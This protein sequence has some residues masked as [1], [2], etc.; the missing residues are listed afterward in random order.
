MDDDPREPRDPHQPHAAHEPA[1]G[2]PL[3]A[4]PPPHAGSAAWPSGSGA[5]VPWPLDVPSE[6]PFD[7]DDPVSAAAA[8]PP[9]V[10]VWRAVGDTRPWGT[11]LV[12]LAWG[13]VFALQAARGELGETTAAIARGANLAVRDPLVVLPRL[14][15]STFLHQSPGHVFFNALT[16]L[17]LGQAVEWV[18]ARAAFWCVFALGG[19]AASLASVSWHLVRHGA[20]SYV[21]LGGSGAVFALG[22]A[23]LPGAWRLRSY[24]AVGRARALAAVVLMLTL[25]G[26]AAGFQTHGTDNAAHAAGFTAG[27]VLGALAPLNSRLSGRPTGPVI[28]VAGALGAL[29]LAVALARVLRG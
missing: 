7:D 19:A 6:P 29:A 11:M 18:F 21:S 22:G 12:L 15:A 9:P 23:L 28:R 26:L 5:E 1:P 4:G 20:G 3:P 27:L 10:E 13:V 25:P 8:E 24:L 16:L 14:L 17:V 2:S